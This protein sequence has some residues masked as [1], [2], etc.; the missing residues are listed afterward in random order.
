MNNHK[1]V[2]GSLRLKGVKVFKPTIIPIESQ[3][4]TITKDKK[5]KDKK[6]KKHKKDKKSKHKSSKKH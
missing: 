5:H 1:V 4:K 3:S 2:G 6:D